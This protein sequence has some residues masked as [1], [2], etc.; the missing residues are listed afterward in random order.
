M[1]QGQTLPF[2]LLELSKR[3]FRPQINFFALY[4]AI[5][6]VTNGDCLRILPVNGSLD[7]LRRLRPPP[8]LRAWREGYDAAG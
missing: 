6:R 3:P 1:L 2:V 7:Y 8:E 4:V 5:S